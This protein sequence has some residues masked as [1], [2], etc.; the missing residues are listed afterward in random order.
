MLRDEMRGRLEKFVLLENKVRFLF[1]Q[2]LD[3]VD[4]EEYNRK[5][6]TAGALWREDDKVISTLEELK[7][8]AD[9]INLHFLEYKLDDVLKLWFFFIGLHEEYFSHLDG[10]H[11]LFDLIQKPS[12]YSFNST[13]S[14]VC[15]RF[16]EAIQGK[17]VYSN[18]DRIEMALAYLL[19]FIGRLLY[20][21]YIKEEV[22]DQDSYKNTF[23]KPIK[24][25]IN[26][27]ISLFKIPP[28]KI[29]L[30]KVLGAFREDIKSH[31]L[32]KEKWRKLVSIALQN[33]INLI[34]IADYLKNEIY[35]ADWLVLRPSFFERSKQGWTTQ[36]MMC[37]L[38]EGQISSPDFP[39]ESIKPKVFVMYG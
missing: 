34:S 20:S 9:D 29:N 33:F 18:N 13:M 5:M 32:T 1:K 12:G 19:T 24:N 2:K 37:R 17:D 3:S 26:N 27:Q 7:K 15:N 14:F 28:A 11:S 22:K 39:F 25:L 16:E 8:V 4:I 6:E 35:K 36:T 10:S 38:Y 30:T 23:D 21:P 31:S